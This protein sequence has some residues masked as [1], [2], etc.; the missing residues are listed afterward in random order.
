MVCDDLDLP[1][2]RVRLRPSGSHGGHRGMRS[3][4]EAIGSQDFP[5]IRIGIGRPEVAGEPTWESEAVVDYV[6]GPMTADERHILDEAAATAGEAILCLLAEG[7]ETAMNR[8][9]R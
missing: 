3:I 4:I 1:L 6:L 8:Y 7:V 5:R 2:G 9:N